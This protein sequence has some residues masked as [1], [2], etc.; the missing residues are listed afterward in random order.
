[1]IARPG[2]VNLRAAVLSQS[3]EQIPIRVQ[4]T[5]GGDMALCQTFLPRASRKRFSAVKT[6]GWP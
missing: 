5:Q 3:I 1:M 4:H 2:R 6:E